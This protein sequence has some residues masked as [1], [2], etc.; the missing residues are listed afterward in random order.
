MTDEKG[1][2]TFSAR[3][4]DLNEADRPRERALHH[5][6]ESLKT[7]ELL[8][9]L[10]GSGTRGES[11]LDLS[12]RILIEHKNNLHLLTQRSIRNFSRSYKGI[13]DA[14]AT[15][16]FAALELGKRYAEENPAELPSFTSSQQVY[17]YIHN[18]LDNKP[19][20]EFWAIYL[21]KANK[22]VATERVSSGGIS[23][24]VVDIKL[25]LR[26][27]LDN[28][29]SSIILAHNHPS[30]SLRPSEHDNALTMKIAK[31]ANIMDI[32]VIDHLI[33]S[34]SGYYSYCDEGILPLKEDE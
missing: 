27:A 7:E 9:I 11:V 22:V 25:L 32:K 23:S 34:P 29:A 26:S 13:G 24:T 33:V 21:N 18:R 30:G 6:I 8:A 1:N 20:E 4:S 31:T 3:I 14:K 2:Q 17:R 15:T 10:L 19:H 5:G 28:L 12:K 16:L